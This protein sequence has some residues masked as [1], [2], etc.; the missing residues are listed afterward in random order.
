MRAPGISSEDDSLF[1][2]DD[3]TGLYG[4]HGQDY[5]DCDDDTSQDEQE[6]PCDSSIN[7]YSEDDDAY[8]LG[9]STVNSL[10]QPELDLGPFSTPGRRQQDV[11]SKNWTRALQRRLSTLGRMVE[12]GTT[13]GQAKAA[14]QPLSPPN[15]ESVKRVAPTRLMTDYL[16][17]YT[18]HDHP[19]LVRILPSICPSVPPECFDQLL[20]CSPALAAASSQPSFLSGSLGS[21][22]H[23][24]VMSLFHSSNSHSRNLE[25]AHAVRCRVERELLQHAPQRIRSLSISAPRI[26]AV[27]PVRS[28]DQHSVHGKEQAQQDLSPIASLTSTFVSLLSSSPF[29]GTSMAETSPA[30]TPISFSTPSTWSLMSMRSTKS[31]S[32]SASSSPSTSSG[33]STMSVDSISWD[34]MPRLCQLRHLH[35][36]EL[37]DIHF[38]FDVDVVVEFLKAHDQAYHT[39]RE[40]KIGGPD[41]VG[42]S[43][44]PELIRVIQSVRTLKVLDMIE[45][46]EATKYLDMIPTRHLESLLL[47]TVRM[48]GNVAEELQNG[49]TIQD[50]PM[51]AETNASPGSVSE[52]LCHPQ[53]QALQQCRHLKELKMPVLIDGLLEW[54]VQER[55]KRI[56]RAVCTG[57]RSCSRPFLYSLASR[58]D[59]GP[60]PVRLERV[61]LSGTSSGP[62]TSTLIHVMDAFRDSVHTLQ[63][64]SWVDSTEV[65]FSQQS[66]G[67]TWMLPRL[68]VL[69]LQGDVAHQFLLRSLQFCP[70]LR[71]LRL[72]L[73]HSVR[74]SRTSGEQV[75][76]YPD[77][78]NPEAGS[79][80]AE[81]T[82][83]SRPTDM[84]CTLSDLFEE[85]GS[86]GG[87][88][89]RNERQRRV[90]K[91]GSCLSQIQELKLAGNWGLC[92]ETLERM[93]RS[94]P[95]LRRLA[96]LRCEGERRLTARGLIRGLC[97]LR[98]RVQNLEVS[99]A[100]QGELEMA[101]GSERGSSEVVLPV[102]IVYHFW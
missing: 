38:A 41:D 11:N 46:R 97:C 42:K 71:I 2:F 75:P 86:C 100:W 73:P 34:N 27:L 69:D 13:L 92:D 6:D 51:D 31:S 98:E 28:F 45:W 49:A 9:D 88:S 43:T 39:I 18:E 66:L 30:S 14:P 83:D 7:I 10:Q 33:A 63:G 47:G 53:I 64:T 90:K 23:N 60:R 78:Y 22:S 15:A 101:F 5:I 8:L 102:E 29:T 50:A 17:H 79:T 56:E 96:L 12:R 70:Q 36:I 20:S 57:P 37:F 84:S 16:A 94:M 44:H 93:M 25:R 61:N 32:S 65:L 35:R 24:P 87:S 99:Q 72:S 77:H 55:A 59:D 68:E 81:E 95:R 52:P 26:E 48:A 82:E 91:N 76:H 89:G 54:A 67:W 58:W 21:I 1:Q 40:L 74:P 80:L 3:D 19:H 85:G 4:E 62:L